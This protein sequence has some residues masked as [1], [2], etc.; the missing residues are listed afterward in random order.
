MP[1]TYR[2]FFS[3]CAECRGARPPFPKRFHTRRRTGDELQ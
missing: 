1:S 3:L 2:F